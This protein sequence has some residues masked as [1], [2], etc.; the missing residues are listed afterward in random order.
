MGCETFPLDAI[1]VYPKGI[2]SFSPGL[3]AV[4]GLPWVAWPRFLLA[5]L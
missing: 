1:G 4:G 5:E 2:S 3:F